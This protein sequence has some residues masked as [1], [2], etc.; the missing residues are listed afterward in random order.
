MASDTDGRPEGS[1]TGGPA[2]VGPAEE[3]LDTRVAGNWRDQPTRAIALWGA[4]RPAGRAFLGRGAPAGGSLPSAR[5]PP[6]PGGPSGS[7][8]SRC[9]KSRQHQPRVRARAHKAVARRHAHGWEHRPLPRTP[10]GGRGRPA[11]PRLRWWSLS[12]SGI[13]AGRPGRAW[14]AGRGH[15]QCSTS[16]PRGARTVTQPRGRRRPRRRAMRPNARA[17]ERESG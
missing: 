17:L 5:D 6:F 2:G 14:L 10:R 15:G 1:A 13:K 3:P 9:F 8:A 4:G 12:S 16:G 11:G 7:S